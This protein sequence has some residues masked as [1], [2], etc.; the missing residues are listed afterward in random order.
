M[1][2]IHLL[3]ELSLIHG[4]IRDCHGSAKAWTFGYHLQDAAEG[5]FH[6]S[7]GVYC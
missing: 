3:S 5:Q 6:L 4:I 2:Y 1:H 7:T